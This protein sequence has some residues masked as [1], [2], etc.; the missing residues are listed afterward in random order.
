MSRGT[1]DRGDFR[2]DRSGHHTREAGARRQDTGAQ[3]RSPG[4]HR[5]VQG[6]LSDDDGATSCWD[7]SRRSQ[8]RKRDGQVVIGA[9]LGEVGRGEIDRDGAVG[10]VGSRGYDRS[11]H[12]VLGLTKR[13]VWEA[14]QL[15]HVLLR[16]DVDFDLDLSGIS[17]D[18]RHR[19]GSGVHGSEGTERV[20]PVLED[21][22]R[23]P[24]PS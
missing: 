7:L 12:P 11:L 17:P 2:S 21:R 20:G 14:T 5:A 19:S 3:R 22:R 23:R 4:S 9:R 6:Q 16:A 13:G 8:H 24:Q 1:G 18:Q 15:E 10:E